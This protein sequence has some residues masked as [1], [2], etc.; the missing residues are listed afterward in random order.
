MTRR[1]LAGF[2]MARGS[3]HEATG[4][5][6]V[7]AKTT[8]PHIGKPQNWR[9]SSTKSRANLV[10]P[11]SVMG[12]SRKHRFNSRRYSGLAGKIWVTPRYIVCLVFRIFP[13]QTDECP[14]AGVAALEFPGCAAHT[15]AHPLPPASPA[16]MFEATKVSLSTNWRVFLRERLTEN[17]EQI[18]K[19]EE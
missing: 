16:E 7:G 15:L 19:Q 5:G 10:V 6:D 12:T 11:A 14:S 13:G 3:V 2:F 18:E 9:N 1:V 4:E 8:G 17:F